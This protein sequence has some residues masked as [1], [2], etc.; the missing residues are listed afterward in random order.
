MTRSFYQ[1]RRMW[2]APAPSLMR[3]RA[4][5]QAL[6]IRIPDA[7]IERL[8]HKLLEILRPGDARAALMASQALKH[9]LSQE[10]HSVSSRQ[11]R[12]ALAAYLGTLDWKER[13][14]Q[15]TQAPEPITA[16]ERAP[17]SWFRENGLTWARYVYQIVSKKEGP[18][19]TPET[20]GHLV[21][22]R[23]RIRFLSRARPADT[24]I[25]REW[26]EQ[27]QQNLPPVLAGKARRREQYY[28][29][30]A[31]NSAS[32]MT[33]RFEFTHYVIVEAEV[34]NELDGF[35]GDFIL[36][37]KLRRLHAGMLRTDDLAENVRLVPV[38]PEEVIGYEDLQSFPAGDVKQWPTTTRGWQEI[39]GQCEP[40]EAFVDLDV[41]R[42]SKYEKRTITCLRYGL[43]RP[44][45]TVPRRSFAGALFGGS[46]KPPL[47]PWQDIMAGAPVFET[48]HTATS[49]LLVSQPGGGI[50]RYA[51]WNE[52]MC[53]MVDEGSR[54]AVA[55]LTGELA[56]QAKAEGLGVCLVSDEPRH[57]RWFSELAP[58]SIVRLD[59]ASPVSL[60]PLSGIKTAE[61]LE[62]LLPALLLILYELASIKEHLAREALT[63][64][65]RR[66]WKLHGEK[67]EIAHIANQ[68]RPFGKPAERALQASLDYLV[69]TADAWFAGPCSIDLFARELYVDV[70]GVKDD[71]SRPFPLSELVQRLVM[72]LVYRRA[73][74][75]R[76]EK[77]TQL[78]LLV[79][80]RQMSAGHHFC[81]SLLNHCRTLGTCLGYLPSS[82]MVGIQD[83][84]VVFEDKRSSMPVLIP[85]LTQDSH[86]AYEYVLRPEEFARLPVTLERKQGL[87]FAVLRHHQLQA[88]FTLELP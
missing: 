67:L 6:G 45:K 27:Q 35:E 49:G 70:A 31:S 83:L 26:G 84:N 74:G 4:F 21:P 47:Q 16:T 81:A 5:L 29:E 64:C 23:M 24:G 19:F 50:T 65:I 51:P 12:H 48:I 9:Y 13:L 44:Y 40:F 43:A 7:S 88:H 32:G 11:A 57:T 42:G 63:T 3:L 34:Q 36:Q 53:F 82:S 73:L 86:R 14:L 22:A 78:T 37:R 85:G 39:N 17:V 62:E 54:E 28:R 59:S 60:N 10:R 30:L 25:V 66:A 41:H 69:H 46:P 1:P 68:F 38:D 80:N 76:S 72:A 71:Y 61:E 79:P 58:D 20:L 8:T 56:A 33:T 2:M 18:V 75:L 52:D 87:S 55:S 15:M 77:I